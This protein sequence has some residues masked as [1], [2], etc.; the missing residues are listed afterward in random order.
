[1]ATLVAND[2]QEKT[3]SLATAYTKESQEAQLH[4]AQISERYRILKNAEERQ[5]GSQTNENEAVTHVEATLTTEKPVYTSTMQELDTFEKL[6]T[7]TEFIPTASVFTTE[8]FNT[9]EENQSQK[10]VYSTVEALSTTKT[11]ETVVSVQE[12]QYALSR[13]AKM[14]MVAFVTTVMVMLALICINTHLI[15]QK[16]A[17]IEILEAKQQQLLQENAQL[18]ERIQNATSEEAIREFA[19]SQGMIQD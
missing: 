3:V 13:V 8:R 9:V 6:P 18:Q 2:Q 12:E 11:A 10:T 5:F 4:N 17:S 16:R 14:I 7:V 15:N 1:M 19:L